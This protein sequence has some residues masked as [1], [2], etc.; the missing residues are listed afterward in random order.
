MKASDWAFSIGMSALASVPI[1]ARAEIYLSDEQAAQI[2]F[3]GAK[4][5]RKEL[6]L[7]DEQVAQIEKA[8]GEKVRNKKVT[9]L[10]SPSKDMV[11]IDQVLGKHEFITLATGIASDGSVRGIEILEY[12]E[13]YGSQV[14]NVDWRKQFTGKDKAAPLKLNSD[15]RN[16]SGA[17]L[18]SAHVTAGVRRI[19]HTYDIAKTSL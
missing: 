6:S 18:S 4:L 14:R 3:P 12:R 19:L 13:S 17:T 5:I 16:I 11:I 1:V 15:I 9:V 7:T 8:S 10:V 2:I